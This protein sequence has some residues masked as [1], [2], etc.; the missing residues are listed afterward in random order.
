MRLV[1]LFAG[2]AICGLFPANL[3]AEDGVPEAKALFEKLDANGDGKLAA[4]EVPRE[5]A[6]FFERLLR[7]ADQNK[8]GELS[9]DEFLAGHKSD[10]GPGLP[11][12]GL[13]GAGRGRFDPKQQFER[14]DRNKDGKVTRDEVP[15]MARE[16]LRPLFDRLGKDELSLD[17]F[18]RMQRPGG[19]RR[20]GMERSEGDRPRGPLFLRLLDANGDGRIS[21]AELAKASDLF[22]Q[23][24]QNRDGELDM[25]ELLG[26]PPDGP[27]ME[28]G[29][30]DR[31]GRPF[32]GRLDANQD[33][34]ITKDEL[35]ERLRDRF[36][37]FD[38]NGDGVL[39]PDEL[40]AG[41]DRRPESPDRP[42]RPKRPAAE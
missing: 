29:E 3:P 33:G 17:D 10:D 39:S 36:D 9:L 24:D 20:P 38:R 18:T 2:V 7:N 23:L 28:R 41:P 37:Q 11:L 14:L 32:F 1:P 34:K 35:P 5:Q 42:A 13:G 22:E 25:F 16:R 26:P 12:N 30:G 31:P 27:R 6:R 15:E 8:D 4:E 19:D 40:P 21:K